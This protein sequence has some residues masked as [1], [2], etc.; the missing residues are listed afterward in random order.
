MDNPTSQVDQLS[1]LFTLSCPLSDYD[2]RE[3]VLPFNPLYIEGRPSSACT[4]DRRATTFNPL[5]IEWIG[6]LLDCLDSF[7]SFQS[8]LH[9]ALSHPNRPTF[10]HLHFQS[11]LHWALLAKGVETVYVIVPFNPLYI[12]S[13]ILDLHMSATGVTS[14]N[15]LYI[16]M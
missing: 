8:S 12:E 7:S 11:S 1:I 14:F 4:P 16:E 10:R 5:Y 15:P 6:S 9:W 13:L 3:E 2:W